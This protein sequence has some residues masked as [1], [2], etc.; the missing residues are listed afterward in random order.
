MFVDWSLF[1]E[2]NSLKQTNQL[3]FSDVEIGKK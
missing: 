2:D 1:A 3:D